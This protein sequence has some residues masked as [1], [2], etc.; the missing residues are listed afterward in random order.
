M[1]SF[2]AVNTMRYT[3][4]MLV[5]LAACFVIQIL[6]LRAVGGRTT[7]SESNFFSSLARL[8]SAAKGKP[9][10]MFLGSSI[11]GRLPDRANGFKGVANMGCDGGS[12]AD[13]LRAMDRGLLSAA[14]LLIIEGNTIFLGISCKETEISKAIC[15][16]WFAVGRS[17]GFVS[18]TARPAAF[19]YS[20]LLAGKIG[21]PGSPQG[22]AENLSTKPYI[23][24]EHSVTLANDSEKELVEELSGIISRLASHGTKCWVVILP[25]RIEPGAAQHNL[26]VAIAAKAGV[27]FWDLGVGIPAEHVQLT[28][29]IHMTPSSAALTMR[30]ILRE[31]YRDR[32]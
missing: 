10:V 17:V 5:T 9:E 4:F 1:F 3:L 24:K 14:P 29:G 18:A 15:S 27:P 12:A 8:Q 32:Q 16:P 23:P 7:K 19:A 25:P 31:V 26:V 30:E 6:A 2:Q 21:S 20:K 11:T 28:D 22:I 13:A